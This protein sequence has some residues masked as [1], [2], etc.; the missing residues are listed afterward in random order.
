MYASHYLKTRDVVEWAEHALESGKTHYIRRVGIFRIPRR[1][2]ISRAAR[3]ARVKC[4][5]HRPSGI[6]GTRTAIRSGLPRLR[7][8]FIHAD[9]YAGNS[10]VDFLNFHS[11]Q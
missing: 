11:H 9:D 10:V 5:N 8:S 1:L 2:V 6:P 7:C 3:V 4:L